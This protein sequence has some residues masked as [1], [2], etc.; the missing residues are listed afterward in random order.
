[1]GELYNR[2]VLKGRRKELR[3]KPTYAE[4]LLWQSLKNQQLEGKKFRRQQ[5]IGVYITDF[6][7]PISIWFLM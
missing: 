1:M 3:N 6:C 2:P 4:H 5:S 7:C